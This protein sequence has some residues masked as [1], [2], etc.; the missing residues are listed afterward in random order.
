MINQLLSS[1]E[2]ER[3]L[4]KRTKNSRVVTQ[5][6][7]KYTQPTR[8]IQKSSPEHS[9][10]ESSLPVRLIEYSPSAYHSP[11]RE[12]DFYEIEDIKKSIRSKLRQKDIYLPKIEHYPQH[13]SLSPKHLPSHLT[14][15][16]QTKPSPKKRLNRKSVV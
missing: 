2:N 9:F 4:N 7:R 5:P 10:V 1:S 13:T 8:Y 6:T 16:P 14:R 11:P 3:R 12:D 15:T